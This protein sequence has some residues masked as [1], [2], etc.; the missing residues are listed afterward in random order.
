MDIDIPWIKDNL[1]DRPHERKEMFE[2][3]KNSLIKNQKSFEIISGNFEERKEKA[4]RIIN[5][6]FNFKV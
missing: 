1:R 3:F 2:S 6:L 5:N 4:I